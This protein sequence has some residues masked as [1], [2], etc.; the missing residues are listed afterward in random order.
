M[1]PSAPDTEGDFH[2][3]RGY[4]APQRSYR[5]DSHMKRIALTTALICALSV[6]TSFAAD[7]LKPYTLAGVVSG[8][9]KDV[10]KSVS[11]ALTVKGFAI[12]GSY[13]PAADETLG[14]ICVTHPLLSKH[15]T[16]AGGLLGFASTLRVGLNT[17]DDGVAVSYTTPAYWG[18]AYYRKAYSDIDA[19][20]ATLDKALRAALGTTGADTFESYGSK[21]GLKAAKLQKYHYM[22]SMP[23]FDDVVKLAKKSTYDELVKRVEARV[24]DNPDAALV[25]AVKSDDQ[26]MALFGIALTGEK[27]EKKFL[28]KIDLAQPRAT[29]FL[30]YEL[31]VLEDSAV[32]L[33]GKYRI[34]LSFPDL[35]MGTFMKIVST[36]GDIADAMRAL[37]E[38][39]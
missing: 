19:D 18:N 8:S 12:A 31:L 28:P 3:I 29:P 39:K 17:T 37:V 6:I 27:G 33:H 24:I 36:P 14:V 7:V 4:T 11:E 9:M 13:T 20:Y 32:M 2:V 38:E 16:A 34:A 26:K 35:S 1:S 23:Y 21:K 30:P 15:A 5:K 22:M 10:Q 25:Y